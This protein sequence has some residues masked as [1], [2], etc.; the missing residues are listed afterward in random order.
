MG[1]L[2]LIA[3]TLKDNIA[4]AAVISRRLSSRVVVDSTMESDKKLAKYGGVDEILNAF[5]RVEMLERRI[6]GYYSEDKPSLDSLVRV[7]Q[8]Q[9]DSNQKSGS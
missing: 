7:E 1:L 6:F 4:S 3:Q 8:K 5:D 9:P 2:K